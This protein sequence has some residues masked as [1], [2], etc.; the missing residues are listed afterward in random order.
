MSEL[1]H[2]ERFEMKLLFEMM[3]EL[4]ILHVVKYFA[5]RQCFPVNEKYV[6]F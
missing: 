6:M 2:F 3:G 1:L 4:V 5:F